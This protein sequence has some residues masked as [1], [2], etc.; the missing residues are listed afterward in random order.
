MIAQRLVGDGGSMV[1]RSAS[2]AERVGDCGDGVQWP[3]ERQQLCFMG[4]AVLHC[5]AVNC[6][7]DLVFPS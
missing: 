5:G 3:N 4:A 7:L 1:W 2:A 6:A